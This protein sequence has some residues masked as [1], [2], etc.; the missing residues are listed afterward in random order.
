M[1]T[2]TSWM[3]PVEGITCAGCVN[4]LQNA[5]NK[6]EQVKNSEVNLALKTLQVSSDSPV[7]AIQ[8]DD[9]VNQAGYQ[10]KK[11]KQIFTVL[12]ISCACCVN[13]IE[14]ALTALVGVLEV[15]VNLTSN[16]VGVTWIDGS[17]SSTDIDTAL[18]QAGYPVTQPE[19]SNTKDKHQD[20]K[21]SD[22]DVKKNKSNLYIS[23]EKI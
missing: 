6:Q 23:E 13:K 19:K 21:T 3:V 2:Q 8:I 5:L 1:N 12:S 7:D 17:L 16:E 10:L 4:R 20:N 22:S 9:W 15:K 11:Q 18:D 14:K